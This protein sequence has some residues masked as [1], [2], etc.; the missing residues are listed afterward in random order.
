MHQQAKALFGEARGVRWIGR[1]GLCWALVLNRVTLDCV[2]DVPASKQVNAPF[3]F[4]TTH[5]SQQG[6]ANFRYFLWNV[7]H[8]GVFLCLLCSC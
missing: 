3:G 1:L 2:F 4:A 7:H 8:H 5:P 6:S